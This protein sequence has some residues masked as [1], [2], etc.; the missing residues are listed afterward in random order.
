MKY[1]VLMFL[2]PFYS[3]A[4]VDIVFIELRSQS[5]QLIQLEPNGQFAH[6]AISYKDGWL[7]SHPFRG[8]EVISQDALEKIGTIKMIITIQGLD[9]LKD[10]QVEKF[11][12]KP[13]DAEF[14]WSDEKIYCSELIGKLL[15]IDPQPMTFETEIW[16]KHTQSLRGQLGL[17]PDDIFQFLKKNGYQVQSI[18]GK[19]SKI[20]R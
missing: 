16:P 9:S 8:V 11:L 1:F 10:T 17:S 13:Y 14:S 7:H 5:G 3:F 20:F 19:C 4:T 15:N 12:G 2:M 6:I 18:G